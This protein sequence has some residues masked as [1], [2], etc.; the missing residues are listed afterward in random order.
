L[1]DTSAVDTEK[2]KTK[3]GQAEEKRTQLIDLYMSGDIT[4]DEFTAARAK[5]DAEITE[6]K[7]LT[8]NMQKQEFIIKEHQTLIQDIEGALNEMFSNMCLDD[9]FYRNILSQMVVHDSGRID[10]HL[11]LLP[12]QWSYAI[13]KAKAS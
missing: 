8:E 2:L 12:F 7:D 3:I 9:D 11:N 5:C 6:F 4:K 13:A 10:V 1:S